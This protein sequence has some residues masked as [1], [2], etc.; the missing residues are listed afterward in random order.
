[1]IDKRLMLPDGAMLHGDTYRVVRPMASG[2]FGNTYEVEHVKLHKRYC[3]KEF[4]MKGINVRQGNVVSVS[5]EDNRSD[6]EL[7][8]TKFLKEAQRMALIENPHVAEVSDFFEEN[9][10]AYYVMRLI[11]GQSLADA[12]KAQGHP[13]YEDEVTALLP[14]MLS[15]L[16]CVHQRGIYHLDLK[17]ANIMINDEGHLWLIDF[18]AS[19]QISSSESATLSSSSGL[20]YTLG[21]APSE[22]ISGSTRHIGAWTDFYSL[23]ATLYNLLTNQRP[24]EVEDVK[25]EGKRA[26]SFPAMMSPSMRQLILWL[27][28]P[29]YPQR[30]QT[31]TD[32]ERWLS[33][34]PEPEPEAP[35]DVTQP[36]KKAD[37]VQVTERHETTRATVKQ[38]TVRKSRKTLR[39]YWFALLPIACAVFIVGLWIWPKNWKLK[40]ATDDMEVEPRE[41]AMEEPVEVDDDSYVLEQVA[42]EEEDLEYLKRNDVWKKEDI[43]SDLYRHLYEA[44]EQG[45]IDAL[46][47][48]DYSQLPSGNNNLN[49]YWQHICNDLTKLKNEGNETA[50]RECSQEMIRLTRSGICDLP[51]LTSSIREIARP[52][53]NPRSSASSVPAST[54]HRRSR[55][56]DG[57][58]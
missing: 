43:K 1:M 49:G 48:H 54:D 27:M 28:Q 4:F 23:G 45:D 37:E 16:R 42:L 35:E 3:M 51:E 31:V 26:F 39:I 11:N 44:I 21:Y 15:A 17:P 18:G 7:M 22:L 13:Y 50:L 52:A 14:Q 34:K 55:P 24:P 8:R 6:F 25:Y 57:D 36:A 41:M 58:R 53:S 30:P 10:T 46:L 19:K 32:I 20:C 9:G 29:D 33:S 12:M 47:S 40:P 2:G 56:T 38:E 5:V